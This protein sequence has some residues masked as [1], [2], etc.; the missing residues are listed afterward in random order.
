M[1]GK[2]LR[3][4]AREG[5]MVFDLERHGAG[6]RRYVGRKH[7]RTLGA[8]FREM[9][10]GGTENEYRQGGWPASHKPAEPDE[11][12]DRVEYRNALRDGDL[13]PADKETADLVG[14]PFDPKFGGEYDA[15]PASSASPALVKLSP[16]SE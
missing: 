6:I 1:Y 16:K 13:W 10:E 11:M 9:D 7:D 15:A 12:P 4:L 14:I 5:R 8:V 2:K 3:V